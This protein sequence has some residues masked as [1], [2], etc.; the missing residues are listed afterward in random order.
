MAP[1]VAG[2]VATVQVE[3][4]ARVEED[5]IRMTRERVMNALS[6]RA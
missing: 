2:R 4:D 3:S 6:A 5:A 1:Q